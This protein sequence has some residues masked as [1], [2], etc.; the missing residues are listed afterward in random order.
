ML[1]VNN[2]TLMRTLV[3]HRLSASRERF[4][5]LNFPLFPRFL[6]SHHRVCKY[7]FSVST[8]K[9]KNIDCNVLKVK[10]TTSVIKV[11]L[12]CFMQFT[13]SAVIKDKVQICISMRY[14]NRSADDTCTAY[15]PESGFPFR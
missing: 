5:F 7:T 2:E 10:P 1:H 9:Y 8:M 15:I 4:D 12:Q 11:H 13:R 3:M 14:V 6:R